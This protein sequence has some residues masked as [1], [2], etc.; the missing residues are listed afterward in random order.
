MTLKL[1]WAV[2][3][4]EYEAGWDQRHFD[5]TV[6]ETYESAAQSAI[7]HRWLIEERR[8]NLSGAT[9]VWYIVPREPYKAVIDTDTGKVVAIPIN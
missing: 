3:W 9:S 6:H 5:T 7:P 4:I 8:R 2:D 1:G